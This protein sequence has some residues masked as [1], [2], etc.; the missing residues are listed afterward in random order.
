MRKEIDF[1]VEYIVKGKELSKKVKIK[2]SSQKVQRDYGDWLAKAA[3]FQEINL[4]RKK[5]LDEIGSIIINKDISM[6]DKKEQI[7]VLN[8]EKDNEEK[9]MRA[10]GSENFI[11]DRFD[12]VKRLLEDNGV[13]D[14]ELLSYKFW[15][16]KVDTNVQNEF[17]TRCIF[18][19]HDLKKNL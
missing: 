11:K 14:E 4:N 8:T 3:E 13:E 2:F 7:T 6:K 10:I 18:K 19:D 16:E 12:I 1:N 15:D 5:A 17:L 9:R